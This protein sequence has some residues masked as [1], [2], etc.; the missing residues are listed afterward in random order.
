MGFWILGSGWNYR[1]TGWDWTDNDQNDYLLNCLLY[2]Y[3]TPFYLK[4]CRQIFRQICRRC[5]WIGD[6][7][8]EISTEIENLVAR[9]IE[10][11]IILWY[12]FKRFRSEEIRDPPLASGLTVDIRLAFRQET[13]KTVISIH[14]YS[15]YELPVR[16]LLI[17]ECVKTLYLPP[18]NCQN[19]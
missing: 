4:I 6:E 9:F 5:F 3:H 8:N 11:M 1:R 16:W 12:C 14:Q 19:I 18:N 15:L 2:H 7:G 13:C 10:W 17:D